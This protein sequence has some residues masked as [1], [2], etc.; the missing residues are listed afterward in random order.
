MAIKLNLGKQPD[1]W[2]GCFTDGESNTKVVVN[3]DGSKV[4]KG[5]TNMDTNKLKSIV[6]TV[7]SY[8]NPLDLL[9]K[10]RSNPIAAVEELKRN[11]IK[12]DIKDVIDNQ[13]K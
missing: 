4:F 6:L 1:N 10:M 13:E 12:S 3:M 5:K 2:N 8:S 7:D 9:R 11:E